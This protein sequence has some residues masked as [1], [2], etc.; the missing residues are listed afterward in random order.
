MLKPFPYQIEGISWLKTKKLALLADQPG[1]GK[2]A[3]AIR[4]AEELGLEKIIIVCPAI[5]K[6]TW[7]RE[8]TKWS[9]YTGVQILRK[10]NETPAP[11][12][13]IFICSFDY[14]SGNFDRL[15]FVHADL[16]IVDESHCLKSPTAARTKAL[17]S[18]TGI[19]RSVKRCWF[20][21]GT[22]MP[23]APHDL[24]TT[25]YTFGQTTLNYDAFMLKFCNTYTFNGREVPLSGKEKSFPELRL[26][27]DKIMLRRKTEEVLKDLPEVRVEELPIEAELDDL[28]PE[29]REQ[30]ERLNDFMRDRYKDLEAL[31]SLQLLEATAS[32]TSSLRRYCVMKKIKPVCNLIEEELEN[33]AYEKIIVFCIH[34]EAVI[35]TQ[36]RLAKRGAVC[37]YGATSAEDRQKAIDLF[38]NDPKCHVI[39][40]NIATGGTNITLTAASEVLFLEQ[41]YVPGNNAQAIAR[42]RR[43]GQK[44]S[45]RARVA[46][47]ADSMDESVNEILTRKMKGILGLLG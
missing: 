37:I 10:R 11:T 36:S 30:F 34:R 41:D 43:I 12:H 39:V 32:S 42:A 16:L 5:A 22:P 40:I 4:A 35:E 45:V 38:Q 6:I 2:S 15:R 25:L 8:I 31:P 23:N 1:L 28:T 19:I 24:W 17:L 47:L 27:L 13:R 21:S 44:N 33:K 18:T 3:Q 29:L 7:E 9:N 14:A 26:M 20:L 46:S